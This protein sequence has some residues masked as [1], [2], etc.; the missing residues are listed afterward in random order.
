MQPIENWREKCLKIL[1]E[2]YKQDP[3]RIAYFCSE[4]ESNGRRDL[5]RVLVTE[6]P[7]PPFGTGIQFTLINPIRV[8]NVWRE[9]YFEE[10]G[11][12]YSKPECDRIFKM[13]FGI[14]SKNKIN[15]GLCVKILKR[16]EP[17]KYIV[18]LFEEY[19]ILRLIEFK[20]IEF[21]WNPHERLHWFLVYSDSDH[22]AARAVKFYI[23]SKDELFIEML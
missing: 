16:I 15:I 18:K 17:Q 10:R 23:P 19:L 5:Y 4:T 22:P 21:D 8:W 9:C 12:W 20:R 3:S 2:I 13:L 6:S 11:K 1:E 7:H 14:L